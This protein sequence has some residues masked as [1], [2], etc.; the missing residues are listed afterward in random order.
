M[1]N[2]I[3]NFSFIYNNYKI[4]SSMQELYKQMAIQELLSGRRQEITD[5]GNGEKEPYTLSEWM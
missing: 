4:N 2:Y 5:A 1:W 3:F